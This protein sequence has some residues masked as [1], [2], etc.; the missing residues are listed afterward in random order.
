MASPI[1]PHTLKGAFIRLGETR[2]VRVPMS[3][4]ASVTPGQSSGFATSPAS[5]AFASVYPIF[6]STASSP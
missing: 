6:C 4:A 5:T 2:I 1:T 3:V